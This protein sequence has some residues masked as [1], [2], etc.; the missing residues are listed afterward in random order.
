MK[1]NEGYQGIN[2]QEWYVKDYKVSRNRKKWLCTCALKYNR[3]PS[4]E[5]KHIKIIKAFYELNNG[6]T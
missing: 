3:D 5:C 2:V 6:K 1:Y 4:I